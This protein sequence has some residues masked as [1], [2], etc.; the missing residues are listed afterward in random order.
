MGRERMRIRV[1]SI[2]TILL[3]SINKEG[4]NDG[5]SRCCDAHGRREPILWASLKALLGISTNTGVFYA[6]WI[7]CWCTLPLP[8]AKGSSSSPWRMASQEMSALFRPR[9]PRCSCPPHPAFLGPALSTHASIRKS[10]RPRP[11]GQG[12]E[13]HFYCQD[14]SEL[15]THVSARY[16]NVD[17]ILSS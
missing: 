6:A 11:E 16:L 8:M 1:T 2:L 17:R 13:R 3:V 15:H 9:L 5:E 12:K 7:A 14:I 10:T 4:L